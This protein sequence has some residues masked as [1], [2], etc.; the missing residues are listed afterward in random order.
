M[1]KQPKCVH[2]IFIFIRVRRFNLSER[3]NEK[4]QFPRCLHRHYICKR[5]FDDEYFYMIRR[6]KKINVF[7]STQNQ[8]ND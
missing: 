5:T 7:N 3:K 6:K 8:I 2:R 1:E 4:I